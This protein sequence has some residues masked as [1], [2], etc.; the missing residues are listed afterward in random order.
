MQHITPL[1]IFYGYLVIINLITFFFFGI[2]KAKASWRSR[3]RISEKTLWTLS[4]IGGSV[5]ALIAMHTFRHKTKKLSFQL[6]LVLI[7]LVHAGIV[8]ALTSL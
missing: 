1:H 3:S 7:I 2:D 4:L 8:T 6:I 5:G